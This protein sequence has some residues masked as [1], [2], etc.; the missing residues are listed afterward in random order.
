MATGWTP[1]RQARQA[2]RIQR[3]RP[4]E[5]STGPRTP[6][7]KGN[8]S[9]NADKGGP[10]PLLRHLARALREQQRGLQHCLET[11]S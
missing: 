10:R 1:Q 8:V 4:W 5:R 7:G 3:W 9:R 11:R 6:A 2:E